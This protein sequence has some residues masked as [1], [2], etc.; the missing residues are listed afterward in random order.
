MEFKDRLRTL[1]KQKHLSQEQLAS[2]LGVTK[3]AISHY[4]RGTREPDRETYLALSDILNVSLDYLMCKTDVT[5]QI[6]SDE[7][8]RLIDAY[9]TSSEV[10]AAIDAILKIGA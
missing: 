2:L 1:R 7:E 8:M 4:E 6:L 10:R 3:Q 9:R 5:T